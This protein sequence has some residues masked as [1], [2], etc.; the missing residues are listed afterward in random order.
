MVIDTS[1]SG[2][3]VRLM[4][5]LRLAF[6]TLTAFPVPAPR[7]T[8]APVPALAMTAAGVPGAV[9][10]TIAVFV[11]WAATAIGVPALLAACL[12]ITATAV[13]CRMIHYDGLADTADGWGASYHRD[14]ALDIMRTSDVGPMGVVAV[15]LVLFLQVTGAAYSADAL[16]GVWLALAASRASLATATASMW[17][18][19]RPDGLGAG[20]I[21]TVPSPAAAVCGLAWLGF[22]VAST[23]AAAASGVAVPAWSGGII[24]ATTWAATWL[25]C[26]AAG[27]AFGGLTGDVLG[28]AVE[29]SAAAGLCASA[30]FAT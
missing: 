19:A 28:A 11:L 14:R 7:T 23:T 25:V 9:L 3:Q 21:G 13:A 5:G 12:V 10:A 1:P 24:V 4:D 30:V 2:W 20:V 15:V 16:V 6:G 18:P 17:R 29:M 26:F 27:R 8:A 22:G